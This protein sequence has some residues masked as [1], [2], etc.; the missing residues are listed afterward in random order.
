MHV[1]VYG[2]ERSDELSLDAKLHFPDLNRRRWR[3][4]SGPV[5]CTRSEVVPN[6]QPSSAASYSLVLLLRSAW[7]NDD[8]VQEDASVIAEV[9]A[10]KVNR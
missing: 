9:I 4:D 10:D 5:A 8:D 1:K 2:A 3:S 7:G 6:W